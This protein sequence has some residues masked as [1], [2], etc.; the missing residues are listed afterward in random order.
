M[1]ARALLLQ[2]VPRQSRSR[3]QGKTE[4]KKQYT[5]LFFAFI[6]KNAPHWKGLF[7]F[8][9]QISLEEMKYPQGQ[10]RDVTV[11]GRKKHFLL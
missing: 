1:E 9:F 4:Q 2:P 6:N 7:G 3:G 5:I 11:P 8:F 10:I